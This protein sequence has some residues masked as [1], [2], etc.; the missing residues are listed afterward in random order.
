[1]SKEKFTNATIF[2]NCD[3]E[4]RHIFC[5]NK[6]FTGTLNKLK[7]CNWIKDIEIVK[8]DLSEDIEL[9]I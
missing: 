5:T 7:K 6:N 3:G 9:T 8:Y 2:Y 1:M 4:E